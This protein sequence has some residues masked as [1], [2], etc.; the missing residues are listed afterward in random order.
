MV[1]VYD[2]DS[3]FEF[4]LGDGVLLL[5]VLSCYVAVLLFADPA[6]ISIVHCK[7]PEKAT[8]FENPPLKCE[9]ED[10]CPGGSGFCSQKTA[11]NDGMFSSKFFL[12]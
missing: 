12:K 11:V 8:F 5:L 4:S 9:V 7:T 3:D 10:D 2:S 6:K 1:T